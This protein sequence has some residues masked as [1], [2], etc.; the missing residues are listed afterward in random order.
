V[1]S[2]GNKP[3]NSNPHG[4]PPN[5]NFLLVEP[6]GTVWKVTALD[7]TELGCERL[8]FGDAV[9]IQ[10]QLNVHAE[11]DREGRKRIAHCVTARQI[12]FLR[13][14]SVTKAA[15]MHEPPQTIAGYARPRIG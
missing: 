12:L 9:A 6:D 4:K 1:G 3:K 11:C 13:G 5:M 15:G 10:G 2:V 7:E 8:A 14:R